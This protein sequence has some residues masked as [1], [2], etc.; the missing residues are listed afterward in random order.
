MLLATA[1]EEDVARFQLRAEFG[2]LLGTN[3][4]P[5]VTGF[6]K[7]GAAQPGRDEGLPSIGHTAARVAGLPQRFGDFTS[8][9]LIQQLVS[10]GSVP[11]DDFMKMCERRRVH[12]IE[13]RKGA[14]R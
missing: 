13:P 3:H 6:A 11:A 2:Q 1:F 9:D 14:L 7:T 5:A 12:Q 4:G 10:G 8:H